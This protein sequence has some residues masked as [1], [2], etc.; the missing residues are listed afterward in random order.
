M[1]AAKVSPLH[2]IGKF[3]ATGAVNGATSV[4]VSVATIAWTTADKAKVNS[5]IAALDHPVPAARVRASGVLDMQPPEAN[6]KLQPAI[7]ALRRTASEVDVKKLP[8]IPYGLNQ[9]FERAIK[10]ITGEEIY[11]RW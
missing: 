3:D 11:Y 7:E 10:A 9:P 1:P 4:D 8:G 2:R 6:G 5:I